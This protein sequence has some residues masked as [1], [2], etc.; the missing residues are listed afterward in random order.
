M[1]DDSTEPRVPAPLPTPP[2]PGQ[3]LGADYTES[4]VPT[5]EHVRDRIENRF[6]TAVGA[7]ELAGEPD[8]VDEQLADRERTARERLEQIR[9]SLRDE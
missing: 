9:R 3:H 6:A 1:S 5:F 8:S 4:G 7:A 2:E